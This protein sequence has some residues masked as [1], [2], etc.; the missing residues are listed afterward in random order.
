[1]EAE[2]LAKHFQG[3]IAFM[4]GIDTQQLLVHASPAEVMNEVSRIKQLLGPHLV[5][6]P[7]H[8]AILPDIPPQNI[9]AMASAVQLRSS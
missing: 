2:N 3:K 8:E 7:S 4:G 9:E 6:S 1:M 5:I